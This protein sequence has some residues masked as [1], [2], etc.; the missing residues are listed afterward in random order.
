MKKRKK[1][2]WTRC[3][4]RHFSTVSLNDK[5]S[6]HQ[7]RL[8]LLESSCFLIFRL[9]LDAFDTFVPSKR[10]VFLNLL[11]FYCLSCYT[12]REY[13]CN[14]F[15][16]SFIY[17]LRVLQTNRAFYYHSNKR[18]SKRK[19]YSASKAGRRFCYHEAIIRDRNDCH[20]IP[21]HARIS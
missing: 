5:I 15:F 18:K 13:V 10:W 8:T 14:S 16:S 17:T 3:S 12:A 21:G 11:A 9:L 6:S 7:K 20:E 1:E 19:N 2:I 4:S